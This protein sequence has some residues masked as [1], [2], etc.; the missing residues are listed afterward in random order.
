MWQQ[1]HCWLK[2]IFRQSA[3]VTLAVHSS[4]CAPAKMVAG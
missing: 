4:F 1:Q 2:V 3:L